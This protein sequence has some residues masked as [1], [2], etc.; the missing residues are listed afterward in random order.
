VDSSFARSASILAAGRTVGV[1]CRFTMAVVLARQ[2]SQ[3]EFGLYK[4][5]FLLQA[6]FIMLLDLGLPASLYYFLQQSG[7]ARRQYVSQSLTL[8]ALASVVGAVA[9]AVGAPWWGEAF[10][11]NLLSALAPQ[12]AVFLGS[13]LV[14]STLEVILIARQRARQAAIAY[15]VSDLVL[16]VLVL[17]TALAGGGVAGILWAVTVVQ[18]TRTVALLVYARRADLLSFGRL[19]REPLT[20]QW[21][22]AIPFWAGHIVELFAVAAPQY[23]VSARY[24]TRTYAVYSVGSMSIPFVDAIYTTVVSLVVVQLTRLAQ[25]GN[26]DQVRDTLGNGIRLVAML[27]L[28]LFVL[29]ELIADDMIVLVYSHRFVDAVPVLRVSL[30]VLPL[31]A[32]QLEYV[33]RAYGDT[34]FLF[35]M[36]AVRGVACVGLLTVLPQMFGLA[37]APLAF[38]LSLVTTHL[39]LLNRVSH[40]TGLP[41]GQVWPLGVLCRIAAVSLVSAIPVLLLKGA[42]LL[43]HWPILA[44]ACLAFGATYGVMLWRLAV[45]SSGEKE[46]VRALGRRLCSLGGVPAREAL[47]P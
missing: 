14:S 38:V 39:I 15:C 24:D 10:H 47:E 8:L 34:R 1:V 17:A 25:A 35:F 2:L 30:L 27:C 22:Y 36:C 43:D 32:T 26:R 23:F 44:V 28:P 45:L 7:P 33:P 21:S 16:A 4:Q 40:L 6:T 12:L 29:L 41:Y 18:A 37:G 31:I 42:G 46:A 11:E 5:A 13:T 20:R 3:V 9:V 19:S